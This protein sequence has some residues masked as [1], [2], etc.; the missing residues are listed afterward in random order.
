MNQ[1]KNPIVSGSALTQ[2]RAT[3]EQ[4]AP[5]ARYETPQLTNHGLLRD[6]TLQNDGGS[7]Q[8]NDGG[9]PL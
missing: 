8:P 3:N 6:L 7:G 4:A 9:G 2:G 5:K 1:I